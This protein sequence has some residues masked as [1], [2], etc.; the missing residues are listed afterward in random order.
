M[1]VA[2]SGFRRGQHPDRGDGAINPSDDEIL[3]DLGILVDHGLNL[4]R[5]YDAGDNSETTLELIEQHDLPIKVLLG[6]WLYAEISNHEHCPWLDEPIPENE[7]KTNASRNA[8]EV[9]RVIELANRFEEIVVA[10]NVGNEALVSWTDHLVSLDD[11]IAYVR[12]VKSAIAQPVSVAENYEWWAKDGAP[13]AAEVDFIGVHSY[14]VWEGK[15]IGEALQFTA[16]NVAGVRSTTGGKSIAVLEAGWP[17]TATEF[18]HQAN[19][20]N[21][22]RYFAD[23]RRWAEMTNTTVFFFEAFDEPWERQ[24]G[25]PAWRGKTLGVV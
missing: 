20:D 22:T 2:Y 24:P 17:T 8:A 12:Q 1:G 9:R 7:L 10:V 25:Q 19:E 14:P 21:Q 18:E 5:L 11:V 16:D 23:M 3:E 6:A 15:V 4:I 13:L